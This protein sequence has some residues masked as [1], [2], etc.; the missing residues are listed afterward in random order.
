MYKWP[1]SVARSTSLCTT[2]KALCIPARSVSHSH[3]QPSRLRN[4][5]ICAHIGVLLRTFL[6]DVAY[7]SS[8]DSGKTTLTESILLKSSFISIPGSV[9]TGS[10]TTDFLPAER[11]RGITIQSASIP[12]KWKNWMFNLIDTPGHADFGMEVESASRV[13]DGAVVLIDSVEGVEAQTKGV[14]QQLD[15]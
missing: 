14:W 8:S 10:T 9:D 11:E 3:T 15:R 7:L 13:V 12:V 6:S 5:A 4:L 1:A 2:R